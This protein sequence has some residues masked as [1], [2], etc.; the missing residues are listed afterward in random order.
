[1]CNRTLGSTESLWL[2]EKK[3]K[4]KRKRKEEEEKE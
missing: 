3:T 1:V 4:R 2:E